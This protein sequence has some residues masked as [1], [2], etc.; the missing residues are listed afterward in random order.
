MDRARFLEGIALFNE[1]RFFEAHE[2]LEEVWNGVEGDERAFLQGL[3]QLAVGFHHWT[4]DNLAGA[5]GVLRRGLH[6]LERFD[7]THSG[8][9]LANLRSRVGQLVAEL[10]RSR[11]SELPVIR[12]I[13]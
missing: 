11:P 5:R 2:V 8:I 3:I 9:A 13:D 6:N 12:L 4:T 10:D 1:H 7:A